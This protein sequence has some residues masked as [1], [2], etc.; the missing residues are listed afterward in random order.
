M[1]NKNK[2][3]LAALAVWA[4]SL[5]NM[6]NIF[7]AS[8]W[9]ITVED[10]DP[11]ANPTITQ[12]DWN[13]TYPIWDLEWKV[14]N[15]L[16]KAKV[17]PTLDMS[18]SSDVLDFGVLTPGAPVERDLEIEVGTNASNGV[19][20]TVQSQKWAMENT[21]PAND[22]T[23]A[24]KYSST[25]QNVWGALD[26]NVPGFAVSN[27]L[28]ETDVDTAVH[29]IYETNKAENNDDSVKDL[30]F[31]VKVEPTSETPSGEYEDLLT[32]TITGRF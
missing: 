24:Y 8:I 28:A 11:D 13:E 32:F 16:V 29:T 5:A 25:N 6:S 17:K 18:I 4:I 15:V 9:N 19:V 12:I 21:D 22:A 27:T 14:E 3:I 10:I 30:K 1:K 2:K 31:G 23:I 20:I 26:S 7:A